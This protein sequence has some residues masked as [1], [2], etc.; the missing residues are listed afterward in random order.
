MLRQS[1]NSAWLPTE[2]FVIAATGAKIYYKE[3]IC[4]LPN[5]TEIT[6]QYLEKHSS[7]L[8]RYSI[9]EALVPLPFIVYNWAIDQ[10]LDRPPE[11]KT[12]LCFTDDTRDDT[13]RNLANIKQLVLWMFKSIRYDAA[14]FEEF[15]LAFF[16]LAW[17]RRDRNTLASLFPC[18]QHHDKENLR[19]EPLTRITSADGLL[20]KSRAEGTLPATNISQQLDLSNRCA[21]LFNGIG[22]K[23]QP[24]FDILIHQPRSRTAEAILLVIECK[25]TDNVTGEDLD[26][27]VQLAAEELAPYVKGTFASLAM[28]TC[29]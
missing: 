29:W 11:L 5:Q 19:L 6:P 12:D 13:T 8:T 25:H 14:V 7:V 27:K 10:Q 24:G 4:R 22:N 23:D 21:I 28:R 1:S 18:F 17:G 3:T 26:K 20:S 16:S 9:G 2:F 15:T